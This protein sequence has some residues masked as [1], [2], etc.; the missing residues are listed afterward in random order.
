MHGSVAMELSNVLPSGFF[1]N[2]TFT[3]IIRDVS[4]GASYDDVAVFGILALFSTGYMLRGKVWDKP[5]PYHHLWFERPQD[6]QLSARNAK[7]ETRNIAKKLEEAVSLLPII[8]HCI[9][10]PLEIACCI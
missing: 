10:P 6:N 9:L 1:L 8:L 2:S 4:R 7:R 5:D 3:D